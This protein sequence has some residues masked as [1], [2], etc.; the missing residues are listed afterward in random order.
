MGPRM[1][2]FFNN[3]EQANSLWLPRLD[4]RITML[5][6]LAKKTRLAIEMKYKAYLYSNAR[7]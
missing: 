5:E 7:Y 3:V 6:R 1:D 2:A 4:K